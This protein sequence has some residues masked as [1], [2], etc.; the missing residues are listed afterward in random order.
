[1]IRPPKF[2]SNLYEN[3]QRYTL[4]A[5]LAKRTILDAGPEHERKRL[6]QFV[7]ANLAPEYSRS[8]VPRMIKAGLVTLNGGVARASAV[9]HRGDRVEIKP[10]SAPVAVSAPASAPE[11]E[12]L[13]ADAELIVVN[14]P[15][16]MTV[17]P[18]PGHPHSTPVDA[19]MTRFPAP[20]P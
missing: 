13:F 15:P 6:D 1:M 11:I 14:K 19:L 7:A 5:A 18:A 8:Q 3:A 20:A 10:P 17:H 4:T 16:G 2:R 12:V 9:L